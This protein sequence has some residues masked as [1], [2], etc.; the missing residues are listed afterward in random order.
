VLAGGTTV[1]DEHDPTLGILLGQDLDFHYDRF[2]MSLYV[3]VLPLKD[4]FLTSGK[5][6]KSTSFPHF[7]IFQINRFSSLGVERERERCKL[8]G[9]GTRQVKHASISP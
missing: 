9:C 7:K 8:G 5:Q 2:Q 4:R 1:V 3:T 6:C